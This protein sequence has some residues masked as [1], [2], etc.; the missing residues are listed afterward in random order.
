LVMHDIIM[1]FSFR[2]SYVVYP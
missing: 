2:L 1:Y